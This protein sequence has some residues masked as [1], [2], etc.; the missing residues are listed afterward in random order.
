MITLSR[1]LAGRLQL[2]KLESFGYDNNI[3]S[4]HKVDALFGLKK[5]VDGLNLLLDKFD[6][7][8]QEDEQ[9]IDAILTISLQTY[10]SIPAKVIDCALKIGSQTQKNNKL[11]W[12]SLISILKI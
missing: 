5:F 11:F 6:E 4:R 7:L 3:L 8:Y 10:R 12:I 1:T 2:S 9:A